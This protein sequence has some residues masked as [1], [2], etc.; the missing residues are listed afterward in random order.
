MGIFILNWTTSECGTKFDACA[1]RAFQRRK[2][3]AIP[4]L[5]QIHDLIVSYLADCRYKTSSIE[6]AFDAAV[7]SKVKLFNP[8][9]TDLKV[10]ITATTTKD[11]QPCIF[12]NYNG[13]GDRP[14]GSGYRIVR[15]EDSS[16]DI[17]ISDA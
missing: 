13:H 6:K 10:A 16:R 3:S 14:T 1:A 11:N 15:A 9:S 4:G 12:T 17:T 2:L 7:G 8:L 5:P